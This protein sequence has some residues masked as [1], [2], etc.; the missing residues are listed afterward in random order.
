VVFLEVEGVVG[1]VILGFFLV[2]KFL[3]RCWD[4][5]AG[6]E[7]DC[8]IRPDG[9]LLVL[10]VP[11]AVLLTVGIYRVIHRKESGKR[12]SSSAEPSSQ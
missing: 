8:W 11:T 7:H 4:G 2:F 9:G 6:A 1:S 3:E 12:G 10:V 5:L